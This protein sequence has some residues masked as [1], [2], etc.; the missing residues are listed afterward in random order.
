MSSNMKS[1]RPKYSTA[2]QNVLVRAAARD[3]NHRLRCPKCKSLKVDA[4][5]SES[6]VADYLC[7]KCGHT[8]QGTKQVISVEKVDANGG[9]HFNVDEQAFQAIGRTQDRFVN[10]F[11]KSDIMKAILKDM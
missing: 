3:K 10:E 5:L 6:K 2:L 4:G 9:F 7:R 1:K 8:W 11:M